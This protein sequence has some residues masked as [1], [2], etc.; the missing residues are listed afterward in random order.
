MAL[1]LNNALGVLKEIDVDKVFGKVASVSDA[2]LKRD[3][4]PPHEDVEKGEGKPEIDSIDSLNSYLETLQV[5]ASPVVMKVLQSQMQVLK[6]V[7]SPTMTL[8]AVDNVM[9]CL[10]NAL[11]TA[12]DDKKEL[13]RECF[14]SL[15]QSFIFVTE[16]R[17]RYEIDS[18]RE[19]AIR[20]LADAGD[21]LMS[22]VN[23]TAMMLTPISAGAKAVTALPKIVNVLANQNEQSNF[24]GRLIMAKGKRA[25]IEEKKADFDKTLNY[26]FDTLDK[27]AELIGPSILLHGMLKRYADGLLERYKIELYESVANK[28]DENE[29]LRFDSFTGNSEQALPLKDKSSAVKLIFDL[30]NQ[31]TQSRKVMDYDSVINIR[32][33]LLREL[34]GYEAQLEKLNGDIIELE[35]ELNK[36]TMLLQGERKKSIKNKIASL[37]S[38]VESV[39]QKAMECKH[40][41]GA[42]SD[43][44]DP[45]N[46]SINLYEAKLQ[47]VVDK[48]EVCI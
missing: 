21:L 5:S 17:L 6:Y 14:A 15:L 44:I 31:V 30:F 43:V 47:R 12:E 18:N 24:L 42:V 36:F 9:Q 1:K 7:Q 20:L 48:Y 39:E 33:T 32:R 4:N 28:I 45:I 13:L 41:I 3:N 26:I 34:K 37:Q 22:T 27:Y 46:E 23:T 25:L 8:M 10:Y 11:K 29:G 2:I 40:K 16:A 19:E 38:E 35:A